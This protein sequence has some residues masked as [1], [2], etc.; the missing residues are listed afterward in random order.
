MSDT[1]EDIIKQP[2]DQ[3]MTAWRLNRIEDTLEK[4]SETLGKLAV[5][6][7]RHIETREAIERSFS[8]IKALNERM[9][10]VELDMPM[11][12]QIKNWIVSGMVAVVGVVGMAVWEVVKKV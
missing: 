10:V 9:R 4:V 3:R 7:Q 12:H 6:E 2:G 1:M 5:L 11:L 8:E